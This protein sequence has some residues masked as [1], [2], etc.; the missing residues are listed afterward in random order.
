MADLCDEC[1]YPETDLSGL[2]FCGRRVVWHAGFSLGRGGF[3]IYCS[4][5]NVAGPMYKAK[6]IVQMPG[7]ACYPMLFSFFHPN[8]IGNT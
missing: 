4:C 8:Q 1:I 6:P 2:D 3:C 5:L 7:C